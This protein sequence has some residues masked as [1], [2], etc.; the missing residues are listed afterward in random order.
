MQVVG[1]ETG[2]KG[3]PKDITAPISKRADPALASYLEGVHVDFGEIDGKEKDKAAEKPKPPE[4]RAESPKEY[5]P[6]R[7]RANLTEY[8]R[9][10]KIP[11]GATEDI[12]GMILT[13]KLSELGKKFGKYMGSIRIM[14]AASEK[15][16]E[17]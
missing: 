9:E 13:N 17:I 4:N 2:G 3:K 12:A 1:T 5:D 15:K 14:M 10:G 8:E 16:D 11:A 6:E 7:L